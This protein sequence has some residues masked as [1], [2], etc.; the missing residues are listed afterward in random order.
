MINSEE[1]MGTTEHVTLYTRCRLN[2]CRYSRF[3][4]VYD[5]PAVRY[6]SVTET[7]VIKNVMLLYSRVHINVIAPKRVLLRIK[8]FEMKS[9]S[10]C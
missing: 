2:R 4:C 7:C 8:D 3:G 6:I 10:C 9:L 1:S 5:W